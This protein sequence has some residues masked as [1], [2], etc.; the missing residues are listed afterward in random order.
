MNFNLTEE[1][2]MLR[3]MARDFLT[4]KVPKSVVKQLEADEKGYSPD[5][6]K[7]MADLGW[8]GLAL[9]EKYGGSGMTFLDLAILLEEMG[10]AALPG[11]FFST[12][13]L[14]ALAILEGGNDE[15]KQKL[16]PRISSGDA[17]LTLALTEASARYEPAAIQLKAT[18]GKKGYT[19]NGAKLFVP[20]AHIAENI[21]VVARTKEGKARNGITVFIV[22]GK[23]P[24]ITCN[25][26]RAIGRDKLFEVVLNNVSV[27]AENVLGEVDKGW[28]L[29][30]KIMERAATALC[31]Q[32]LGGL[33]AATEM[34]VAYAKERV[35]FDKPIGAF[36]I[37]Q[38]Y[39]AD[40]ATDVEGCRFSAYQAA[41][42]LSEGLP[43]TKE[44]AVAK[45]W[46]S[47]VSER[48]LTL[49]HQ[50]HGAMGFTMDHDLHFYTMRTKAA[51]VTYGDADYYKE[52]VAQA[53]G[54]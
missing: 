37:M 28:N 22:D 38:H 11:P 54:I 24:G 10:R 4:Q 3:K 1:Q 26:L 51:A 9:P 33:E 44:V 46:M 17:I 14:A 13:I 40:M 5:L 30:E 52:V 25:A 49:A 19:L 48:V 16:L 27:P 2:E 43:C 18:A 12:V 6:W 29:V 39:C 36:Q 15:Q 7:E 45:A 47:Q 42:L 34:T 23:S 21:L 32:T 50:I 8:M 41:W 31:C 20:D 35:Q 53:M